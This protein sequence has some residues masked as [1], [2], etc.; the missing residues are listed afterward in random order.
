[1]RNLIERLRL[2]LRDWLT[3]PSAAEQAVKDQIAR[4]IAQMR[5]AMRR[6]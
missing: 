2:A 3:A 1:M 4:D 5:E 6:D